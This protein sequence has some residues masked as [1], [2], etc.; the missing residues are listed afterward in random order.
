MQEA[1]RWPCGVAVALLALGMPFTTAWASAD[2]S[3]LGLEGFG[4]FEIGDL[5]IEDDLALLYA[6]DM[7][8]SATRH[9]QR[10]SK[11]PSTITVIGREELTGGFH[12]DI[13]DVM[14]MVPG[15]DVYR[16]NPMTVSVGFRAGTTA[17]ANRVLLLVDGR[18]A[19]LHSTGQPL[20]N[21][22]PVDLESIERIE[23][24]R[25]PGSS[26]Y[27]AN[28]FQGVVN[29]IT[30]E[31]A[32]EPLSV[33][34]TASVAGPATYGAD[35]RAHG[36]SGPFGWWVNAGYDQEGFFEHPEERGYRARRARAVLDIDTGGDLE[37]SVHAGYSDAL[38]RFASVIGDGPAY[39]YEAF[40]MGKLE[41]P[42][43]E[44]QLSV[45][46]GGGEVAPENKLVAPPGALGP[47]PFLLG[48][49]EPMELHSRSVELLAFRSFTWLGEHRLMLGGT[50]RV[51]HH[52]EGAV[53]DCPEQELGSFDLAHCRDASLLELRGGIFA[54]AEMS[55]ADGL[56]LTTGIRADANSIH[57]E[58]GM[59]PRLA[60]VWTPL[61]D[62]ALRASAG[63]A[64]RKPSFLESQLNLRF[65]PADGAP[66][67]IASHLQY[68]LAIESPN[69][70]LRNE[71]V[72]AIELGWLGRFLDG[73]IVGSLD[74]YLKR[75]NGP[76]E[77]RVEHME[78]E[79]GIGGTYA[80]HEDARLTYWNRHP[81]R[82][83]TG[84]EAA[85][86]AQP[87]TW[88]RLDAHYNQQGRY[89]VHE[90]ESGRTSELSYWTPRHRVNLAARAR[91]Q[92]GLRLAASAHWSSTFIRYVQ[93]PDSSLYEHIAE[94][95]GNKVLM[96]GSASYLLPFASTDV[97]VGIAGRN[98]LFT[99]IR[100]LTGISREEGVWGGEIIK[101]QARLFVRGR[102]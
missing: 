49:L 37:A 6:E 14:R 12:R 94:E 72:D 81:H 16:L 76:I 19:A 91:M 86:M 98:L 77:G 23:V 99:E 85:I 83:A 30:R 43:G 45:E 40:A 82:W 66:G 75:F 79:R 27:G 11:S 36:T 47:E 50:G 33:E 73:R 1:S 78:F 63:R 26:V 39:W 35:A 58:L 88:L 38:G 24:I 4:D 62:H 18:E 69:A 102:F 52:L 59:S 70:E 3:D 22:L 89:D 90:D 5:D 32:E 51:I 87:T 56:D 29:I 7:V 46:A 55:V 17:T 96:L 80:I 48:T 74:L 101:P 34:G 41:W 97:E 64:Y 13:A 44:V 10:I 92:N 84:G 93:H 8:V 61:S 15:G 65:Q 100:E 28:A 54:Q 95:K 25:G 21:A 2:P 67:E 71:T 53:L 9:E 20:W 68:L 60:M 57:P 42:S 31:P